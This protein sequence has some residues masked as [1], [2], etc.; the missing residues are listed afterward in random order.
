M[1]PIFP[2]LL[3]FFASTAVAGLTYDFRVVTSGPT[4]STVSG[5]VRVEGENY[6]IDFNDGDGLMIRRGMSIVGKSGQDLIRVANT[7]AKTYSEMRPGELTGGMASMLRQFGVTFAIENPRVR[8]RDFGPA[9]AL[10]GF[11]TRRSR[12]NA[13]FEV[14][15]NLIGRKSVIRVQ[16]N[17]ESWT[18]DRIPGALAAFLP[19]QGTR[20]GIPEIDKLLEEQS[21]SARGFP[22][23]QITTVRVIQEG[24]ESTTTSTATISGI[25]QRQFAVAEFAIPPG[26]KRVE[27]GLGDLFGER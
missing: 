1:R 9:G 12:I 13:N 3:F 7:N 8:S 19:M 5:N 18:T 26:F 10:A 11:P 2:F 24:R 4:G 20:T 16:M 21:K 22:L 25:S 23:K 17:T 27:S 15:L 14:R 6:R